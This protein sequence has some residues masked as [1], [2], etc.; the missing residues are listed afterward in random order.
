ME[1]LFPQLSNV[2]EIPDTMRRLIDAGA[3]GIANGQGFYGYTPEQA[4]EWEQRLIDN[5][6]RVNAADSSGDLS[7]D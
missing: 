1:R 4:T 2:T 5:V 6:W 3:K 7:C